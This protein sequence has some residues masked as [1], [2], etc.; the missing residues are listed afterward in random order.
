MSSILETFV[1]LFESN[2][3]DVKK[4]SDEAKQ[5]SDRL[6]E[7]L[8]SVDG[9]TA[10]VGA[11]FVRMLSTAG[12]ALASVLSVAAI[13]GAVLSAADNADALGEFTDRLAL[14]IEEVNAW[15]DAV[16]VNG[17]TAEG[18][19]GSLENLIDGMVTFA[20]KGTSRV[21]PFFKE[22]GISMVD[23]NGKARDVMEVLPELADSF[24]KLTKQESAGL[25]RKLGLDPGTIM[26]LQQGRREV[27][28]QIARQKE[29]GTVTKEAAE[30]AGKFNDQYDDTAKVFRSLFTTVGTTILPLFTRILSGVADIGGFFAK[31]SDFIVGLLIALGAAITVYALPPLVSMAV[32]AVTAFAPFLLMGA[33]IAGVAVA[34]A[35]LYDDVKNFIDGNDSLIGQILTEFPVIGDIIQGVI[36][37]IKMLWGAVS[38]VFNTI[39]S[40]LQIAIT[41][42]GRLFST[43]GEGI[44]S[45]VASSSIV[46]AVVAA[47]TSAFTVAGQNIGA[48]WDFL[49]ARVMGFINLIRTVISLVSGIAGKITGALDAT[50]TK[51]GIGESG[52]AEPAKAGVPGLAEG[53]AALATAGASPLNS[54]T[55]NAISNS[56]KTSNRSTTVAVQNVNV[57]TQATDAEGIAG[58]IGNSMG[59]QIRQASY[60]FDDGVAA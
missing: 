20:T 39:V 7:S 31:H 52:K 34:F 6:N 5:S 40:V 29:L 50:K 25:G 18:F 58:A 47:I 35:L 2:A 11:E 60:A 53:K 42:W 8:K 56:S 36:E 26:L 43:I 46:Q 57:Q 30:I 54:V 21:A 12:G 13:T 23:A 17:G 15:G 33:L 45:F 48:V 38:W 27:D 4:G 41:V 9:A 24:E 10:D 22:L 44:A 19:R 14:N 49:S 32:A 3:D 28:A 16:Q 37:N 1:L 59:Q 51:L 55:S